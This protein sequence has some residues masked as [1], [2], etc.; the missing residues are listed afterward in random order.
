[1]SL[2]GEGNEKLIKLM[3]VSSRRIW[4]TGQ[5]FSERD[6]IYLNINF[7]DQLTG[8]VKLNF[9]YKEEKIPSVIPNGTAGLRLK[10]T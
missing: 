3:C 6:K 10:K 2:E 8:Y 1:M 5:V 9:Q 4:L 7:L